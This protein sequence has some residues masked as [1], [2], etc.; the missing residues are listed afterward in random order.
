MDIWTTIS[1]FR[2]LV[3]IKASPTESR[4]SRSSRARLRTFAEWFTRQHLVMVAETREAGP[5]A[6]AASFPYSSRACY[7]GIG[8]FSVYVRRD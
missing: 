7:S 3:E 4:L 1:G 2:A 5:I 6:F 8:E